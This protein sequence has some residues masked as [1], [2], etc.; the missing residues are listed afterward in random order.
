M[1]KVIY[2][3]VDN[4]TECVNQTWQL[5]HVFDPSMLYGVGLFHGDKVVYSYD[6]IGV[7]YYWFYHCDDKCDQKSYGWLVRMPNTK[8]ENTMGQ[9]LKEYLLQLSQEKFDAKKCSQ[10]IQNFCVSHCLLAKNSPNITYF[11]TAS[12]LG[13]YF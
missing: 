7:D 12:D 9:P 5:V 6:S 1:G 13:D 8:P 3:C 11:F 4:Y 2:T 10:L